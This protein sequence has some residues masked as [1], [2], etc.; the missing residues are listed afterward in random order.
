MDETALPGESVS[1]LTSR[2][3]KGKALSIASHYPAAIVIGSDQVAEF[4]DQILGK[5]KTVDVAL[6]QL[7]QFSGK[8]IQFTSAVCVMQK[9][10]A[11]CKEIAIPTQ[12]HFR[13]FSEQEAQR[14]IE[15][16][17]P[18]DCAGAFKSES[19]G[20]VLLRGLESTDPTALIGLPL[21]ALSSILRSA[22]LQ[23]P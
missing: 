1:S 4:Q 2:L 10:S 6:Q 7:V 5:P 15:L 8:T 13:E 16:D 12:V 18:L 17:M 20:S 3:A 21:I 19:A 23:I 11:F 14:Y 22:G 9:Q